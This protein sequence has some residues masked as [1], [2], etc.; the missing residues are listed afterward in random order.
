MQS[1]KELKVATRMLEEG[2]GYKLPA[3]LDVKIVMLRV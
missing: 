2:L 1:G 3:E